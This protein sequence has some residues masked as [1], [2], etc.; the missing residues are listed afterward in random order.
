MSC[1]RAIKSNQPMPAGFVEMAMTH[2]RKC[3]AEYR[4]IHESH[5]ASSA[6]AAKQAIYIKDYLTGEH[7]DPKHYKHL[8]AYEPLD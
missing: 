6:I 3:N 7:V 5:D 4:I 8:D 2:C 1:A